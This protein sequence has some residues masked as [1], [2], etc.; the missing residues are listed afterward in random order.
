MHATI[1]SRIFVFE[2]IL[3]GY[4]ELLLYLLGHKGTNTLSTAS[5]FI[6]VY[7]MLHILAFVENHR[8]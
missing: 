5:T 4:T 8:K 6:S 2:F 3:S 1:Q 7:C